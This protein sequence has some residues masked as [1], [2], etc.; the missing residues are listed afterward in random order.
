[1]PMGGRSRVLDESWTCEQIVRNGLKRWPGA[2]EWATRHPTGSK[3]VRKTP[4]S[5]TLNVNEIT[6]LSG[7]D[8]SFCDTG[9]ALDPLGAGLRLSRFPRV[10]FPGVTSCRADGADDQLYADRG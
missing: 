4:L 1:M 8:T 5:L 7:G 6:Y 9:P 3:R 2:I 10:R